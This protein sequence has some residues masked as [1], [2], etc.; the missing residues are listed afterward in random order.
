MYELNKQDFKKIR[1]YRKFKQDE[2]ALYFFEKFRDDLID[3]TYNKINLNF[4]S[5][6]LEKGDLVHLMWNAL[7][8]TL[9]N[10]KDNENFYSSLI[11]NCYLTTIREVKKFISNSELVMNYSTSLEK[12]TDN[13][14]NLLNENVTYIS[15]SKDIVLEEI[16]SLSCK[17]LKCY[18]QITI[19]RVIYLRSLGWTFE[20]IGRKI[21]KN[22][23]V[24]RDLLEKV[25]MIVKKFYF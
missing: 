12:Y 4:K 1:S 17:Y 21:R 16:I 15:K 11:H 7:K 14:I 9:K 23:W 2:I 19:K 22:K 20:E 3:I 5:T 8:T 24:V 25:K 6:P 18:N 13:K 10:Y